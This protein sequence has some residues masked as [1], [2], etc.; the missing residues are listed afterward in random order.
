MSK[1]YIIFTLDDKSFGLSIT[2]IKEIVK[3]LEIYPV[4]NA[5]SYVEGLINLRSKVHTVYNLKKK[6]Y[7]ANSQ[8]T[9][10]SRIIILNNETNRIGLLVDS[11][12]EIS[13]ID[14]NDYE[15][16][17]EAVENINEKFINGI[18]KINDSL[19]ILLDAESLLAKEDFH[20]MAASV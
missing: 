14:E 3:T 12:R 10:D 18:A 19:V 16:T 1:Q 7:S 6:F 5:P 13:T 11:V 15:A 8:P 17:P 20:N 2:E 9:D 4:P